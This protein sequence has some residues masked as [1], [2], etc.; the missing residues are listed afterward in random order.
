M[1][2]D[3]PFERRRETRQNTKFCTEKVGKEIGRQVDRLSLGSCSELQGQ[4]TEA[5]LTQ[6]GAPSHH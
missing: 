5:N 1:E 2:K 6:V 4:G 3:A